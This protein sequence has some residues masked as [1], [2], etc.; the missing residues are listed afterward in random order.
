MWEVYFSDFLNQR[1]RKLVKSESGSS[2]SGLT[3]STW[4][5]YTVAGTGVSWLKI[6][7]WSQPAKHMEL[8][9]FW[10][11]GEWNFNAWVADCE[12]GC[13]GHGR[14]HFLQWWLCILA[15]SLRVLRPMLWTCI[16]LFVR[17][18]FVLR[19]CFCETHAAVSLVKSHPS[20]DVSTRRPSKRLADMQLQRY[21]W[22]RAFGTQE[23]WHSPP[24]RRKRNKS[25]APNTGPPKKLHRY[26]RNA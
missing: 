1:L 14:G 13:Q 21:L 5:I 23:L 18:P 9:V 25:I 16:T 24:T 6:G 7:R 11:L 22:K 17:N 8:A 3:Q 12:S 19:K 10:Y 15:K 26:K 20:T 4:L 2:G